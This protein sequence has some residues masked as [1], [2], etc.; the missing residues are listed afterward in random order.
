VS[1]EKITKLYFRYYDALYEMIKDDRGGT[2]WWCWAPGRLAKLQCD[3]SAM[4]SPGMFKEFM[5]PV[6]VEMSARLDYVMYHWDG[7]G[8]L[9]HHDHLL[10]IKEIDII[11]WTP[12]AGA[13]P[14]TDSRW[15]PYYHKTI[16]AGKKVALLGFT[17]TD[18]LAALKKEFGRKLGQFLIG[19]RVDTPEEAEKILGI[20]TF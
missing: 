14:I 13:E 1:L 7:P 11:Q 15:W 10:S 5:V 8:A 2:Y 16:D 6:L 9:P 17:G 20:V 3:T 18:N 19:M 12:G 4:F